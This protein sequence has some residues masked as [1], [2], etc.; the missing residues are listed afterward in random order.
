MQSSHTTG[1]LPLAAGRPPRGPLPTCYIGAIVTGSTLMAILIAGWLAPGASLAQGNKAADKGAA[2]KGAADKKDAEAEAEQ[3]RLIER[4]PFDVI[5]LDETNKNAKLEIYPIPFRGGRPPARPS[6]T[7]K[8]KFRL[9]KDDKEYEVAWRN[10]LRYEPFDVLLL[11]EAERLRDAGTN[12]TAAEKLQKQRANLDE[13]FEYYL[14]LQTSYPSVPGLAESLNKY[15]YLDAANLTRSQDYPAALGVLETLY[16]RDNNFKYSAGSPGVL[17]VMGSLLTKILESYKQKGDYGSMRQMITRVAKK[18]RANRPP[19]INAMAAEL[20]K[21][22]AAKRDEARKLVQE[23]EYHAA[24]RA[25]KEMMDIWPLV[26]GATELNEWIV[27]QFPQV[28]VGV[29]QPAISHDAQRLENWGA[30]RT[31][32]LV[33][34]TLVEFKGA[35]NEGGQY[36]LSLGA[37][38]RADDYRKLT[39][40]LKQF[41]NEDDSLITGYQV[42]RRLLDMANPKS[43]NYRAAWGGV[44]EAANVNDVM[45]VEVELRQ[46][47]VLPE[48]MLRIP[49]EPIKDATVPTGN[50]LFKVAIREENRVHFQ[51]KGFEPGQRLAEI[52][53]HTFD[54]TQFALS[55][56]RRGDVD[57]VDRLFPADAARLAEDL[58]PND[59]IAVRQ[60]ALPTIHMLLISSDNPFL[61]N[62][63]YRRA[64]IFGIHREMI[65]KQELLGNREIEGCQLISGPFAAGVGDRNPLAYAYDI[66]IE[67]RGYYPRLAKL[68]MVVAQGEVELMA[69]K[70]H[71]PK[72]QMKPF[73][74]GHPAYESARLACQ[75][76]AAHLEILG[77]EIKLK[78]FAPGV[79]RDP[80]NQADLTYAEVAIWEPLV[81]ARRLLGREELHGIDSPYLKHALRK[82]DAAQTWGDV[83]DRLLDLHRTAHNEA[84]VIPLWQMV[85][86][87]AYRKQLRNIVGTEGPPVWLYQNIGQWRLSATGNAE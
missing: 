40:N 3:I 26:S 44:M 77:V 35:G 43:P 29:I 36:S 15:L 46:P 67:P 65:L 10:I 70:R 55:A 27:E 17:A 45:Q 13:A 28:N 9:I 69:E 30:R 73:V 11:R 57:V 84:A 7:S 60:Y 25:S 33:H 18:Y 53:E 5:T 59:S 64:L 50:G 52:V 56:L 34:R 32:M 87:F 54:D 38:Q 71:D 39:L 82:L 1:S 12:G 8:I 81:D 74:L 22:A 47:H 83:R 24:I 16:D 78:E 41:S 4:E 80:D 31:G 76:I 2:D 6:P 58:D 86:S 20:A 63:D 37:M 49:L 68:L 21:L 61:A 42:A 79:T 72:P 66:T 62:R 48:S 75:A 51:V 23:K 14:A 85:D 19:A